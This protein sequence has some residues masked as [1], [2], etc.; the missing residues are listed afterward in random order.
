[1]YILVL[2]FCFSHFMLCNIHSFLKSYINDV[3]PKY[4]HA[5]IIIALALSLMV[6]VRSICI[7][8]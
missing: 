3:H 7:P 1:M 4:N 6:Y 5:T 2:Y 8:K